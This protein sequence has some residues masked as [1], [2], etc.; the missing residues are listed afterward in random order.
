MLEISIFR[1]VP[2]EDGVWSKQTLHAKNGQA[3][4]VKSETEEAYV[5]SIRPHESTLLETDPVARKREILVSVPKGC[6]LSIKPVIDQDRRKI[7]IVAAV[8]D[9]ERKTMDFSARSVLIKPNF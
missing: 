8:D 4:P 6:H 5:A 2:G 7:R 9:A 1:M 3:T